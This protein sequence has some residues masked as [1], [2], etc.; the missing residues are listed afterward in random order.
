MLRDYFSCAFERFTDE[1][2]CSCRKRFGIKIQRNIVDVI[3][4]PERLRNQQAFV[5]GPFKC[6]FA[7]NFPRLRGR[8]RKQALDVFAER[9]PGRRLQII[10]VR[11]QHL[12]K[13][14]GSSENHFRNQSG[15]LLSKLG[16]KDVF[17]FM[18]EFAQFA[19]SARAESPFRV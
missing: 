9:A 4:A 13:R 16:C 2:E 10:P 12:V 3:A 1:F 6:G 18:R 11:G 5:L 17:E 15:M 14:V 8:L 19:E 7:R